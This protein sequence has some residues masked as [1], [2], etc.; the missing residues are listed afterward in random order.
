MKE[1]ITI[2]NNKS[3]ISANNT[4][5]QNLL[6]RWNEIHGIKISKSSSGY[7]TY[8]LIYKQGLQNLGQNIGF[9]KIQQ[10]LIALKKK[11]QSGAK[12]TAIDKENLKR[13]PSLVEMVK[14]WEKSGY[15]TLREAL[16]IPVL[17]KELQRVK[18]SGDKNKIAKKEMEI[19]GTIQ[20]VI[21][22]YPQVDKEKIP[23]ESSEDHPAK[24]IEHQEFNCVGASLLAGYFLGEIGI[25]Y[26]QANVNN[27]V[28]TL[29]ITSDAK[30][31][32]NDMRW[33]EIN[34]ELEDKDVDGG[35]I[36]DILD[37][38]GS[39]ET[40]LNLEISA[41]SS[42]K[43]FWATKNQKNFL[44]IHQPDIGNQIDIALNYIKTLYI[45]EG[46]IDEAIELCYYV[47]SLDPPNAGA[48]YYLALLC[49]SENQAKNTIRVEESDKK[50]MPN[51]IFNSCRAFITLE[52]L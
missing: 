36:Q 41:L 44:R 11:N 1:S 4:R 17:Q 5:R 6:N 34:Q 3:E 23:F 21:G 9:D 40:S 20:K 16:C 25:Q 14:I 37:F 39:M 33:S 31:H 29:V 13:L 38:T 10:K 27:H 50:F 48:H 28:T 52:N 2:L 46:S 47:L 15:K 42:I 19:V 8:S 51:C 35:K 26:L 30:V 18:E 45:L 32:L 7:K 22:A 12:M 49:Y 43:L 24:I